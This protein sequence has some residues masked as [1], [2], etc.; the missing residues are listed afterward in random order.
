MR[1]NDKVAINSLLML[2]SLAT[3]VPLSAAEQRFLTRSVYVPVAFS[4]CKHLDKAM[5]YE[6]EQAVTL[7]PVTR[8]FQ[9]TYYPELG[10]TEPQAV[11]IRERQH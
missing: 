8:I 7:L 3:S 1:S 5:L 6:G 4:A 10:R 11:Q 9:F 2:S